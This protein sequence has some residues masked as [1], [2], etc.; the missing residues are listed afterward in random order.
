MFQ[1]GGVSSGELVSVDSRG[2]S[3]LE[4]SDGG[5]DEVDY[6]GVSEGIEGGVE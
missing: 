4:L 3:A 2:L 6:L 5:D 1:I